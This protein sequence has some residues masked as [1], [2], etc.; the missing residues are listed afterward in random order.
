MTLFRLAGVPPLSHWALFMWISALKGCFIICVCHLLTFSHC[1]CP[2]SSLST[3]LIF[4]LGLI[5][6]PSV[7][8]CNLLIRPLSFFV[9]KTYNFNWLYFTFGLSFP[10]CLSLSTSPWRLL[11]RAGY[12]PL[13][14]IIL[15]YPYDGHLKGHYK[16]K[17]SS[18]ILDYRASLNH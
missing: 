12:F 3:G 16:G 5:P 13:K 18:L 6:S 10:L 2:F 11:G 8:S 7:S 4:P 15:L 9:C 1:T 17:C 14:H